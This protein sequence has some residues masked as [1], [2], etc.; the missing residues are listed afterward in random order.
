M[1]VNPGAVSVQRLHDLR[2]RHGSHL[3]PVIVLTLVSVGAHIGSLNDGLFFDDYWH[4]AQF[5][6]LGWGWNDLIES[7][8]FDVPGRLVHHWWQEQRLLWRYARPIA[9]FFMKAEF[10]LAEGDPRIVHGFALMWHFA[11]CLSVYALAWHVMRQRRWALIAACLFA[12]HPQSVFAVS[13]TAARNALISGCLLLT[14]CAT[15]VKAGRSRRRTGAWTALTLVLWA[16]SLFARESAIVFPAIAMLLDAGDGGLRRV[17][18]RWRTYALLGCT[19]ILYLFWRLVIF[20]TTDPPRIY[21]SLPPVSQLPIWVAS[22]MFHML[23]ASIWHTPMFLGVATYSGTAGDLGV[24]ALLFVGVMVPFAAYIYV[25]RKERTRWIW[26]AWVVLGFLPVVPV[27]VMPHF[28]YVP[29]AGL[30]I[31]VALGVRS[32]ARRWRPIA[33]GVIALYGLWSFGLYRYIWRGVVRCEQL[34]YSDIR[35]NTAAPTE[36]VKLFFLNLPAAGI[37]AA[38]AMRESWDL[39][40]VEGYV[41]T[42]APHPLVMDQDS[43]VEPLND[44]E[45]VVRTA[46]PGY[47]AGLG[48]Q[49]LRDG[50]R[51]GSP[52]T[53]GMTVPGDLFDA[54]VLEGGEAGIT[55]LKFSFHRPLNSPDYYFFV[56]S[57]DRPAARLRFEDG[58]AGLA[59]EHAALFRDARAGSGEESRSAFAA[60]LSLSRI[61]A[62]QIADP[63]SRRLDEIE[64]EDLV[65]NDRDSILDEVHRWWERSDASARLAELERW[66]SENSEAIRERGIYFRIH[67]IAANLTGSSLLL[68]GGEPRESGEPR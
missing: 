50:M 10:L 45:F 67:R 14:A 23:F 18:D 22:K 25:A 60:V 65:M 59:P 33:L 5:R 31:M 56:G 43:L 6:T 64:H 29:A 46:A 27:F 34:V 41:L 8:T 1:K 9:M 37:Y 53:A 4:R 66:T 35:S 44:H 57:P 3:F 7:A 15:Y 20:P 47:F 26:P 2:T 24:H 39:D 51:P 30:G 38:V 40:D 42:Y 48:G 16:L 55:A 12:I 62:S 63:F 68:A 54:T 49:M 61:A 17:R 36:P 19:A 11:A 13:W 58:H 52:L 28:A 21:F 32:L